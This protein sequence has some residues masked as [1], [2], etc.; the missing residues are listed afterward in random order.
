MM[1]LN[2]RPQGDQ[3]LRGTRRMGFH[4]IHPFL[5]LA[6]ILFSATA[7]SQTP[8]PNQN[9]G[10]T[11]RVALPSASPL[12]SEENRLR[13][14]EKIRPYLR[15]DLKSP[16]PDQIAGRLLDYVAFLGVTPSLFKSWSTPGSSSSRSARQRRAE[17]EFDLEGEPTETGKTA[18]L[19]RLF[20]GSI[21]F[22][23]CESFEDW[24]CLEKDSPLLI[25]SKFR[26]DTS[27]TLGLPVQAGKSLEAEIFFTELWDVPEP[28]PEQ[29]STTF[30]ERL[31]GYLEDNLPKTVHMAIYGIDDETESFQN[32]FRVIRKLKAIGTDIRAVFDVDSKDPIARSSASTTLYS[33][34]TPFVTTIPFEYKS[35][36]SLI[37]LL[38]DGISGDDQARARIELPAG[39]IMHN[40][41]F[42]FISNKDEKFVFTGTA[43]I[44][45]ADMGREENSNVGIL[46][47][48][49][50]IY[51]A[52][53][54]E[55]RELFEPT[56]ETKLSALGKVR[57]GRF[58]RNKF[59]NSNRYFRFTDGTE[60]RVHF[61]PTDDAEHRLI[62]PMLLS[63]QKGDEIRLSLFAAGGLEI[64]RAIQFALAKG[65]K[66]KIALDNF[67][68]A[69]PS[70]I[71]KA[72][73]A[74]VFDLNPYTGKTESGLEVRRSAWNGNNHEKAA[75]LSRPN[76]KGSMVP[77]LLI[78]GSQNWTTSGNDDNDENVVSIQNLKDGS[79]LAEAFNRHFD[80][81]LWV[82]SAE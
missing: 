67:L 21:Q 44:S 60:V 51:D 45:R 63:A 69:Q 7:Y 42:T 57:T 8:I 10:T 59:P 36:G 38:N 3:T 39:K 71:I 18:P 24:S 56:V 62:I 37:Q 31:A 13:L 74:N 66:V 76:Q 23:F 40:K 75:S 58:H 47:K 25:K 52:Y 82:N 70:S 54:S 43:N 17:T 72:P 9:F 4:S 55:F 50:F 12:I 78:V 46:I 2:Q 14:R 77:I 80:E 41:F 19:D 64:T 32:F 35:T 68:S 28:T 65:A 48:N 16:T 33:G 1:K 53:D 20:I 15:K 11:P 34:P 30:S 29:L 81:R 49:P 79:P 26:K 5:S 6:L 61:S 73:N 22:L 27:P